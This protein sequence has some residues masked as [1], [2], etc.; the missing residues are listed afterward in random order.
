MEKLNSQPHI[1]KLNIV[2]VTTCDGIVFYVDENL[3][4]YSKTM[5]L[6]EPHLDGRAGYYQVSCKTINNCSTNRY[7]HRILAQA[8]IKPDLDNDYE[9]HHKDRD[10]TNNSIDNLEVLLRYDHK[11]EHNLKYSETKICEVC[12]KEFTPHIT[13]RARAHVCSEECKHQLDIINGKKRRKPINQY[14]LDGNYLATWDRGMSIEEELGYAQGN[15]VKCCKEQ[16]KSAYG[17]IWRYAG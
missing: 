4:I 13:K 14:D 6:L 17:Y 2:K 1:E 9:V 3:N 10:R 12:G 5:K 15:I 7:V 8:F 11:L 16:I